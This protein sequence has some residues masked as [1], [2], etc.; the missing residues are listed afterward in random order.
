VSWIENGRDSFSFEFRIDNA[1]RFASS[2]SQA[3]DY[4]GN[5]SDDPTLG[6]PDDIP[7][8]RR[9]N[10]FYDSSRKAYVTFNKAFEE[11][12]NVRSRYIQIEFDMEMGERCRNHN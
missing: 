8:N 7:E 9:W 3:H 1:G 2:V 6:I 12:E 11:F 10:D 5:F 4:S